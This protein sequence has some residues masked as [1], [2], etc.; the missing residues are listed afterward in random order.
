MCRWWFLFSFYS[1][2]GLRAKL[3]IMVKAI[4]NANGKNKPE[5]IMVGFIHNCHIF[6]SKTLTFNRIFPMS[7]ASLREERNNR[8][9][10]S[11]G[12]DRSLT[13]LRFFHGTLYKHHSELQQLR[14]IQVKHPTFNL[15]SE[16]VAFFVIT[17]NVFPVIFVF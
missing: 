3:I 17:M 11:H 6:S 5:L 8:K 7:S 4:E 1:Y 14:A 13:H 16:I 12:F 15:C 2:R 10:K 9:K